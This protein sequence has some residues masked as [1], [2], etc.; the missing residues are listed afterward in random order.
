M[1]K[2]EIDH[3]GKSQG[4]MGFT[5]YMV[6][7]DIKSARLDIKEGARLIEGLLIGRQY[8]E[9]PIITSR[10]CGICPIVHNICSI[11]TLEQ[12][13]KIKISKQTK[14]WRQL[15]LYGQIL[16]SHSL[17]LY[18]L[19]EHKNI[20][21]IREFT[22]KFLQI[23]AGR[24]IHPLTT[25]IGGFRKWPDLE[26]INQLME[27]YEE[28]FELAQE[29]LPQFENQPDFSRKTQYRALDTIY[30]P[31]K[32]NSLPSEIQDKQDKVVKKSDK[33]FMLGAL[34]RL[35]LYDYEKEMQD[36][37]VPCYN[38]FYNIYAQAVEIIYFLKKI[39]QLL[40]QTIKPEPLPKI[41]I[42]PGSGIGACEAPRGT[43]Y[44]SYT[45]NKK[46]EIVKCSIITP[47]AQFMN[48]LEADLKSYLKNNWDGEKVKNLIRAY[49]PC[50]S[51][52]VH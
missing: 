4:H 31:D 18:I 27:N 8:D 38:P 5:A 13:L 17:H 43:L 51:C 19:T 29:N 39:K 11:K 3:I 10:I 23:V 49:D 25:S 42:K 40:P 45:I 32:V 1:A 26:K 30:G 34:A 2:I 33:T 36:L 9:A 28:I 15:L 22:N 7:G 47:T 50:I 21:P 48:N 46:G 37:A 6:K 52:A 20:L 16:Q 12:A 41:K 14:L 24:A 35:H 44:H